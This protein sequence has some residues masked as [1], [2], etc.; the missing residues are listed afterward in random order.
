MTGASQPVEPPREA[1]TGT[2]ADPFDTRALR[3]AVVHAWSASGTRLREDANSEEDHARGYYRDRVVVELAQNAADAAARAH[4]PGRLDLRL[5][6][7]AAADGRG[8]GDTGPAGGRWR[9]VAANSGAPLDA[10]GVASLASLRASAKAPGQAS[11][12]G[13]AGRFGVGFAATRSVAD[14]V[15]VR[16]TT[17]GVRF[18]LARTRDLLAEVT[19]AVPAHADGDGGAGAARLRDV[20]AE[21]GDDLPVLRLPFPAP[22]LEPDGPDAVATVVE[23][24]LRDDAVEAVRAQLAGIDDALLLA[25]PA[26]AEVTVTVQDDDGDAPAEPRTRVLRDVEDRWL[27]RRRSGTVDEDAVADLPREQRRTDWTV[28]WALPRAGA[29]PTDGAPPVLHAPTPT[30]VPLSLPGLLVATFPV[31]PGRRRV[32][33]GTLTDLLAAEAGQAF[34]DA[35]AALAGDHGAGV[36]DLVPTDLPAGELDAA[37]R[38]AAL[39]ALR[40]TPLLPAPGTGDDATGPAVAEGPRPHGLVAPADA[41]VLAGD[42]GDDATL[43]AALATT[44]PGLVCVPAERQGVARSLG[45]TV[46][47]L[48]DV[49]TDLPGGLPPTRWWALCDALEPHASDPG[50]LEALAGARVPLV[51]G[52][53]A[54]GVR[55]TVVLPEDDDDPALAAITRTLGVRV[56]HPDAAHPLL[57]R[58]GATP[59]SARDLLDD[60]GVRALA[61]AAAEAL[62]DGADELPPVDGW[63]EPTT[64]VGRVEARPREIV[65]T[66]L[67]LARLAL[68]AGPEG[69]PFWLGELPLPTVDGVL[70]PARETAVPGSWAAGAMDGL[71]PVTRTAAAR[72]GVELLRAVGAHAEL[73]VYR[74]PGVFT[75]DHD[76]AD[77]AEPD[78]GPDD[79]AGWLA[80]WTDY[81]RFLADRLGPGVDVGEVEAVA[82]LDAVGDADED[83]PGADDD[84][85]WREVLTRTAADPDARRALVTPVA[86][87]PSYTAWWLRR[88]LG[89]PFAR[90]DDVPL[91]PAV[92][93]AAADLDDEVLRALGAVG[94]L[95][96]LSAAD[97]PA[98][99]DRL[100]DVG[101]PVPLPVALVVW[102]GIAGLA[103]RLGPA[104]RAE[105]LDP[106]PDRLPAL[107]ASDVVVRRA[108]DVEVAGTAR[109]AVLGPVLPVPAP[110]VAAV[111]DLLDLAVVGEDGLPAPDGHGTETPLDARVA[112]LDPRL[113]ATW[114]RHER[115][116]VAGSPVPW[117]V[118]A[119]GRAHARDRAGLAAALAD[120]LGRPDRAA[121]L[122]TVLADPERVTSLWVT[123]AW[124]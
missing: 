44:V 111:A 82:D 20:V 7:V 25:L 56:V 17:G 54:S 27:V 42:A 96:E 39:D 97:W 70:A 88:R 62:L 16:S 50:V 64:F 122:A 26:L 91:L 4:V 119:D 86:G 34:A 114:F 61:L 21:R 29:R 99:L 30:D 28:A 2:S 19:A 94:R 120:L 9:L 74:V 112:G 6:R 68:P 49:V 89:A 52:R 10:A 53:T 55:G 78:H 40:A 110:E 102:R 24:E 8:T 115:L 105:A 79:P 116:S 57:V 33:P 3:D 59:T 123:T 121:L 84:A 76:L 72:H 90:R 36:L 41:A 103:V 11:P 118:D 109:W 45:V 87:A 65:E 60:D 92:P 18:S 31:D 104:A 113:P 1:P 12:A 32:L 35:L 98:A 43:V 48:A 73:A 100:P 23:L 81:L 83:V 69:F 58:A 108:D 46:L 124:G 85:R 117:W 47:P 67:A 66:A 37:V 13:Q 77:D 15:A 22:A 95:E 107:D 51:D 93:P 106:L 14:D 75:P 80:G 5:E 101:T 38:D 63:P 71:V